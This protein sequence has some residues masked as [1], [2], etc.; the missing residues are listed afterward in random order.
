VSD[1]SREAVGTPD[2]GERNP[3]ESGLRALVAAVR[4]RIWVFLLL[5]IVLPGATAA[6]TLRQ[7]AEYEASADVLVDQR[8]LASVLSGAP[9]SGGN[10]QDAERSLATQA[11]LAHVPTI[12]EQTL[13]AVPAAD[14]TV[15]QFLK[16]SSVEPKP[17][18]NILHMSVQSGD[19]D[20]AVKLTRAYAQV[21]VDS[22]GRA[23]QEQIRTAIIRI[24]ERLATIRERRSEAPPALKAELDR[25]YSDLVSQESQLEAIRSVPTSN[26]SVVEQPRKAEQIAPRPLRNVLL[27]VALALALGT[28]YALMSNAFN[29]RLSSTDELQRT[30]GMPL[31]ARLPRPLTGRGK[32]SAGNQLKSPS[33]Q[34]AEGM[35]SLRG[36]LAAHPRWATTRVVVVSSAIQSEGKSSC[37][38]G[39]GLSLARTGMRVA[40]V[41]ADLRRP[42]L[43]RYSGLNREPGLTDVLAGRL[44]LNEALQSVSTH[45]GSSENGTGSP[46]GLQDLGSDEGG[47]LALLSA[48]TPVPTP[49]DVLALPAVPEVLGQLTASYDLVILDAAPL[50]GLPDTMA[51]DPVADAMITVAAVNKLHR[52]EVKELARLLR[53][54]NAVKLGLVTTGTAEGDIADSRYFR[55]YG[56][57]QKTTA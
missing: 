1:Y 41:D 32:S 45:Y 54:T 3:D 11:A 8:D 28:G 55:Y 20:L 4:Q 42:S 39:L 31:I 5:L 38:L 6:L 30:L 2:A 16:R 53:R 19:A 33:G 48:G 7:H 21:Y 24:R 56:D 37:S 47:E 35:A 13:K 27:A 44:P 29:T 9:S 18:S 49:Q 43:H 52:A 14:L 57:R 50:L 23:A 46:R 26:L 40:L 25:Q 10:P 15:E 22:A 17:N 36:V 12:A 51:L 34:F